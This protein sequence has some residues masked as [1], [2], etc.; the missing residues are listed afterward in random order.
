MTSDSGSCNVNISCMCARLRS[1]LTS[2]GFWPLSLLSLMFLPLISFTV[3]VSRMYGIMKLNL[4]V[5]VYWYIPT[6][7]HTHVCRYV[8][9]KIYTNVCICTH[10]HTYT[11]TGVSSPSAGS[12]TTQSSSSSSLAQS[13]LV[14]VP[15]IP[16]LVYPLPTLGVP[17]LTQQGS[18]LDG[19]KSSGTTKH[20]TVLCC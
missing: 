19:K 11:H 6:H 1:L 18:L 4:H 13:A 2:I 14:N 15:N 10:T 20:S 8:H 7:T 9:A 17:M 16:G 5:C 3:I 12:S